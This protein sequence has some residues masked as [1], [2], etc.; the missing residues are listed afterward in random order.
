[1][2]HFDRSKKLKKKMKQKIKM[3]EQIKM[4]N[5]YANQWKL[6]IWDERRIKKIFFLKES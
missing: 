5:F 1:M 2:I 4:V 3:A 6:R